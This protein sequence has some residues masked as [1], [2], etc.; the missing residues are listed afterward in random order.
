MFDGA[1]GINEGWHEASGEIG[2]LQN[3]IRQVAAE[4]AQ[5]EVFNTLVLRQLQ[6]VLAAAPVGIALTRGDRFELASE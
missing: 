3:V 5:M 1:H 2:R 4:R 6:S